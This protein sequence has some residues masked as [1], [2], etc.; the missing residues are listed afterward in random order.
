MPPLDGRRLWLVGVGGAGMSGYALLAD[1]WGAEVGGWDRVRTPYLEHLPD[2]VRVEISAEPPQPPDGFEVYV[3]TAFADG[4][5]G[6]S[7]AELLAEL[8]SLRKSIVVAGAHGKTTTSAMVAYALRELGDDPAWLIGGDV[9]QLGAN[10]GA[11]EGW[12]VVEG[13]ESDRTIERLRPTIAVVTN[14][15]LDHHSTFASRAEVEELF[16]RW[17]ADVPHVVR[18]DD[19][20]P[21]DAELAVVGD[22]NRRNA[23]AARAAL[24]HA[25]FARAD[26]GRALSKFRGAARRLETRGTVNGVEVVDDYAHHPAEIEATLDAVRDGGRVLVLFQ[27]HLVSRTRH[28]ARELARAL[29]RA[30]A[31]AVADVYAAREQPVDTV[32]GKL[33]VD[34]LAELRP[35]MPLAW[36]PD[37]EDGARFLAARAR[38]GDRLVVLGAGDVDR[39]VPLLLREPT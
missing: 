9:P 15:D 14:V 8:V 21:Y 30:D 3:S 2:D 33:V 39:V 7:R 31:V 38:S 5:Q 19:L 13:D 4:V 16:A 27:P 1:A 24:E 18:G 35:G 23:A 12:L 29:A 11:G 25:G 10:A 37:A 26:V 32:T 36:T 17:L 34:A 20:E 6:S 28:L 22:H